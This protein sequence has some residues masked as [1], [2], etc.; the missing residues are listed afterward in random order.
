MPF[1]L[2]FNE[3]VG[4]II[5]FKMVFANR[6]QGNKLSWIEVLSNELMIVV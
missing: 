3:V 6:Y 2:V 5:S 4:M 1:V